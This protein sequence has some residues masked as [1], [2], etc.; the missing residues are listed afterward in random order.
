MG[1]L[2]RAA[3]KVSRRKSSGEAKVRQFQMDFLLSLLFSGLGPGLEGRFA[4][5]VFTDILC[6]Q[7]T[8]KTV[9][10]VVRS[11]V[12]EFRDIM[13]FVVWIDIVKSQVGCSPSPVLLPFLAAS[14]RASG[15]LKP[16][17][18]GM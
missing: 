16:S 13:W 6:V 15:R 3:D 2:R 5:E 9:S 10:L 18:H 17:R 14:F 8:R 1:A 7:A 12:I 4:L 11:P